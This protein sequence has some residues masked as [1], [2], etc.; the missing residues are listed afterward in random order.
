MG[1][2]V[3]QLGWVGGL[4]GPEAAPQGPPAPPP[5]LLSKGLDGPQ[6]HLGRLLSDHL[7][8]MGVRINPWGARQHH[9]GPLT[10]ARW[11]PKA[12][13]TLFPLVTMDL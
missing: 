1:G 7:V 10:G 8:A 13:E 4:P 11:P 9:L 6:G 2:W 12:L 3:G 5:P